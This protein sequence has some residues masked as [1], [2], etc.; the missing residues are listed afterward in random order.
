MSDPLDCYSP[1]VSLSPLSPVYLSPTSP[2]LS[3]ISHVSHLLSPSPSPNPALSLTP[4]SI[5]LSLPSLSHT[6]SKSNPSISLFLSLPSTSLSHPL[7]LQ[8]RSLSP[9]PPF[10]DMSGLRPNQGRLNWFG[11]L[12]SLFGRFLIAF[13]YQP[14]H[15]G[16]WCT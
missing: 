9:S 2:F 15:T 10:S 1:Q 13:L 3:L 12:L 5:S 14:S 6:L 8:P 16:A 7:S 4:L 11:F